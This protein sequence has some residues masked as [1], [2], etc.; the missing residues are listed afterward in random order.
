VKDVEGGL[1][2][3]VFGDLGAAAGEHQ[4]QQRQAKGQNAFHGVLR[5]TADAVRDKWC[6][7][8][9]RWALLNK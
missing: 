8:R 4:H 5:S 2:L 3:P 9:A 6:V 1:L 7:D